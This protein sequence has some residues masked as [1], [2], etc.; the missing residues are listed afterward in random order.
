[1]FGL[2]TLS[3]APFAAFS[4]VY[5]G[6]ISESIISETDAEV[7]VA[8]FITVISEAISAMADIPAYTALGSVT[9]NLT[10]NDVNAG[11]ANFV[12][13][14][15]ESINPADVPTVI[16]NFASS[17]SES[18]TLNDSI[19]SGWNVVITEN[20][21]LADS[22][23]G[24]GTFVF[25]VVENISSFTDSSIQ[26]ASFP[27]SILEAISSISDSPLG[28]PTY[29]VSVSEGSTIAN[30]QIGGWNVSV[31]ENST[32]VDNK[33]VVAAFISSASENI[34][35]AD[36]PSVIASFI[37]SINESNI[38]RDSQ[39]GRGWFIINDNQTITWVSLDDSQ[40]PN[41]VQ[42]NNSQ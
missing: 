14:I 33:T 32:I 11:L 5:T 8:T 27:V 26:A 2:N 12:S 9:E 41:W 24:F 38:I 4:N 42:I 21:G 17:I 16:A 15:S 19:G 22:P 29:A 36:L 3:Q 30:S 7:V 31:V 18:N 10:A 35:S 1:M 23:T 6:D 37:S 20:S 39:Y 25:A 40:T 13:S 28:L 34:N